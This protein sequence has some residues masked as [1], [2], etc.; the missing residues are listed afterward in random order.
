MLSYAMLFSSCGMSKQS[1]YW[2][3]GHVLLLHTFAIDFEVNNDWL[4]GTL[5]VPP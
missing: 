4:H 3:T 1:Q 2:A 5:T